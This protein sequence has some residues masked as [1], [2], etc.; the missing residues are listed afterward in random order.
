MDTRTHL[1]IFF[2]LPSPPSR[3]S[4]TT[5]A[6]LSLSRLPPHA[7]L[8]C[9]RRVVATPAQPTLRYPWSHT[10]P[11]C[12]TACRRRFP[13]APCSVASP[14]SLSLKHRRPGAG[15]EPP[16]RRRDELVTTFTLL[17]FCHR[18]EPLALILSSSASWQDLKAK[19]LGQCTDTKLLEH[20][21]TQVNL[22]VDASV[23]DGYHLQIPFLHTLRQ[24]TGVLAGMYEVLPK[25]L[26]T[27]QVSILMQEAYGNTFFDS[28]GDKVWPHE[29]GSACLWSIGWK[30][31]CVYRVY[32]TISSEAVHRAYKRC[33]RC[34]TLALVDPS[35]LQFIE[36]TYSRDQIDEMHV[37]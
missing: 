32:A 14:C 4:A 37:E 20:S 23:D 13:A 6:P 2:L 5:A 24:T 22:L 10:A 8:P 19:K 26:A 7:G 21:G 1:P 12:R 15:R 18:S 16:L 29:F 9:H 25:H 27:E 28:Y 3:P 34:S 31:D 17:Q 36:K 11:P 30:P 35:T 33:H